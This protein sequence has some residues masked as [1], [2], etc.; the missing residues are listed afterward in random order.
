VTR[1]RRLPKCD[2]FLGM[3]F[4]NKELPDGRVVEL[5][6]PALDGWWFRADV[7]GSESANFGLATHPSHLEG[8][9][10]G[11][12]GYFSW[13]GNVKTQYAGMPE[14][15]GPSNFLRAHLGIV[16]VLDEAARL[17]LEVQAYDDG[18]YWENRDPEALLAELHR[19]NA[20]MAAFGQLLTD[21]IGPP[22]GPIFAHPEY[23]LLVA[24]GRAELWPDGPRL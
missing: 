19:W 4:L 23:E 17:G 1:V 3:R 18:G 22:V 5:D 2:R 15:G 24:E 11:L 8:V 13:A 9:E 12:D 7:E 16:D 21:Q 6:V 10:T 20:I 14:S